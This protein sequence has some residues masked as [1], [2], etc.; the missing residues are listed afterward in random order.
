MLIMLIFARSWRLFRAA[1]ACGGNADSDGA[2]EVSLVHD[3]LLHV[4]IEPGRQISLAISRH[5]IRSERDHRQA[6]E[7]C[8]GAD[9]PK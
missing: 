9:A 6:T 2:Q 1:D 7:P 3:R 8:V 5:G 4:A